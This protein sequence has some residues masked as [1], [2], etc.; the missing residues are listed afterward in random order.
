VYCIAYSGDHLGKLYQWETYLLKTRFGDIGR[1]LDK[2]DRLVVLRLE[3]FTEKNYICLGVLGTSWYLVRY[4]CRPIGYIYILWHWNIPRLH[5]RDIPNYWFR[6]CIWISFV[7]W[8]I[9]YWKMGQIR[10]GQELFHRLCSAQRRYLNYVI[11]LKVW[12]MLLWTV[13]SFE[14]KARQEVLQAEFYLFF[15]LASFIVRTTYCVRRI[16]LLS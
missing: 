15:K 4:I 16:G 8:I 3:Y 2:R 1:V 12:T 5:V 11:R 7:F 13:K 6:I 9:L 10:S 14:W